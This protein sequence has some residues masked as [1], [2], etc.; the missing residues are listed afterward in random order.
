MSVPILFN[1]PPPVTTRRPRSRNIEALSPFS[2]GLVARRRVWELHLSQAR[3]LYVHVGHVNGY[4][5]GGSTSAS[6][7]AYASAFLSASKYAPYVLVTAVDRATGRQLSVG[8][9]MTQVRRPRPRH[10]RPKRPSCVSPPPVPWRQ[11]ST[12][13]P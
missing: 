5:R 6:V 12:P 1:Q 7:S 3:P 11:N 9:S 13:K 4:A 10:H 2:Q 8:R